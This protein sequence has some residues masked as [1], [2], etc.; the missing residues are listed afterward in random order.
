MGGGYNLLFTADFNGLIIHPN[1]KG[2]QVVKEDNCHIWVKAFA[3][4]VW[5]DVVRFCV[6]RNYGGVENLYGIPFKNGRKT[7]FSKF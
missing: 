4:E 6:E 7:C 5:D 2:I 1:L 3:G